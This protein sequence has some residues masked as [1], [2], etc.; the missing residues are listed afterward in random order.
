M[1]V[2]SSGTPSLFLRSLQCCLAEVPSPLSP[3]WDRAATLWQPTGQLLG[4]GEARLSLVP[5][6]LFIV[7]DLAP[8][9]LI[10]CA[11]AK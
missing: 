1:T 9:A 11:P 3:V 5:L 6:P 4:G 2:L 8:A 7:C 10:L